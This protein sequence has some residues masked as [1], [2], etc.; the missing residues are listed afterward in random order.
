MIL[1]AVRGPIIQCDQVLIPRGYIW[2]SCLAFRN[3]EEKSSPFCNLIALHFERVVEKFR[4]TWVFE[5]WFLQLCRGAIFKSLPSTQWTTYIFCLINALDGK[6]LPLPLQ[7]VSRFL[8]ISYKLLVLVWSVKVSYSKR[9]LFN[10]M[11]S[12][13]RPRFGF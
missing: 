5:H 8:L 9:P 7:F 6:K 11:L 3:L 12:S 2:T 1:I 13:C 10:F 4:H